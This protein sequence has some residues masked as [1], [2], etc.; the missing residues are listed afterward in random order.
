M[1]LLT[2]LPGTHLP[3]RT[4]SREMVEMRHYKLTCTHWQAS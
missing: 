2:V 3:M 4:I 1:N